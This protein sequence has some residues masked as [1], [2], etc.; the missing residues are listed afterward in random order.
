[1]IKAIAHFNVGFKNRETNFSSAFNRHA[2]SGHHNADHSCEV[3][4]KVFL[5]EPRRR[6]CGR[7]S[8]HVVYNHWVSCNRAVKNAPNAFWAVRNVPNAF[9]AVNKIA[10]IVMIEQCCNIGIDLMGQLAL[11]NDQF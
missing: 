6:S 5:V 4:P 11:L 9:W 1:L 8:F 10:A 3:L 2:W 7:L